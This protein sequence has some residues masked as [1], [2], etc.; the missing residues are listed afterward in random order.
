MMKFYTRRIPV[1]TQHAFMLKVIILMLAV[2]ASVLARYELL[3]WVTI[4]TA[5]AAV[6]T[7]WAEFGDAAHKV[8]RYSSAINGLKQLL[9]VWDSLS[10]VRKA[11][12]DSITNLVL[13]AEA[14]ICEEQASWTSTAAK[15]DA[16]KGA[17]DEDK[18]GEKASAA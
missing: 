2:T 4:A 14:I 15:Q 9:G 17:K 16:E 5:A 10:P 13:T 11:S 7:S 18:N 8:E 3:S 6:T 12:K 1:Y